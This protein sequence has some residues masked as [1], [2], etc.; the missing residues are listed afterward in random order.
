MRSEGLFHP[1]LHGSAWRI[2]APVGAL[3]LIAVLVAT[4]GVR[5]QSSPQVLESKASSI[6]VDGSDW[7]SA[8]DHERRAFLLGIANLMA[9]EGAYAKRHNADMPFVSDQIVKAVSKLKFPDIEAI[10]TRWYKANPGKLSMPVMGV[11]WQDIAG[12]RPQE[13]QKP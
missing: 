6:V 3:V 5:A 2:T 1:A 7:M 13:G 10:I 9:A 12:Q 11:I 8:T 4:T